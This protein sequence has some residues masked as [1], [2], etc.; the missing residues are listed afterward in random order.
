[1]MNACGLL[2]YTL[3]QDN[4]TLVKTLNAIKWF[5]VKFYIYKYVCILSWKG[6]NFPQKKISMRV[7]IKIMFSLSHDCDCENR[8]RLKSSISLCNIPRNI[9][10]DHLFLPYRCS[11][12]LPHEPI[13]RLRASGVLSSIPAVRCNNRYITFHTDRYIDRRQPP[14]S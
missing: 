12:L 6:F 2:T 8:K 13:D 10:V 11:C 9:Q 14:V 7:R 5:K 3:L 1:M 4:N